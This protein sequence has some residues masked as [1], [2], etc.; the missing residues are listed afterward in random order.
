[1]L[2]TSQETWGVA[3]I[4]SLACGTPVITTRGVDIW[5]EL[6]A[7]GAAVITEQAP[8][9]VASALCDLLGSPDRLEEMRETGRRWVLENLT[10][11]HV[12][13]RYEELYASL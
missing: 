9:A 1:M 3:L 4:E 5:S 2:P 10:T 12:V 11:D 7:S 8:E 6:E 13:A